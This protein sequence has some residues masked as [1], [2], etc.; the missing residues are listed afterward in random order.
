MVSKEEPFYFIAHSYGCIIA[1]ELAALLEKEGLTGTLVLID[2][3]PKT[4]K[5]LSIQRIGHL[6]GI[7]F[8]IKVLEH[9]VPYLVP[10]EAVPLVMVGILQ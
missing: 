7:D 10:E 3:S 6:T 8:E 1:L 9:V 5:N 4:L 2:G